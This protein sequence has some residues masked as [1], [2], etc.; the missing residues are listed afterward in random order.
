MK[1]ITILFF[2]II[3]VFIEGCDPKDGKLTLVNT[4]NDT[5]FY[6]LTYDDDDFS[7]PIVQKDG[8]DNYQFSDIIEPNNENHQGVMDTWEYFID[9]KSKDSTL[10]VFF[11]S[12]NLIKTAGKDSIMKNQLYSKKIN[13]KVEDLKRLNWRVVYK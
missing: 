1:P 5:I 6:S 8:K 7:Y 2:L 9:N 11:F 13:L 4:T 10:R 3:I 12:K